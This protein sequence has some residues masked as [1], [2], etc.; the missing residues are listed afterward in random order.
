MMRKPFLIFVAV[1]TA[2]VVLLFHLAIRQSKEHHDPPL[3]DVI[4]TTIEAALQAYRFEY[5]KWPCS[6]TEPSVRLDASTNL[7]VILSG[8]SLTAIAT[9]MNPRCVRYIYPADFTFNSKG[10]FVTESGDLFHILINQTG[11]YCRVWYDKQ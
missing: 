8:T 3:D 5:G 4:A 9:N 6:A 2:S 7:A 11:D 10:S 1:T